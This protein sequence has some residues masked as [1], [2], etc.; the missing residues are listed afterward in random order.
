MNEFGGNEAV[1]PLSIGDATAPGALAHEP[2]CIN[3]VLI[4]AGRWRGHG[5]LNIGRNRAPA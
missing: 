1:A 2:V 4:V 5:G 3:G